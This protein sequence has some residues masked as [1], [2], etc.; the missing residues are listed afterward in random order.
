MANRDK[1]FVRAER[2]SKVRANDSHHVCTD[3]VAFDSYKLAV[4]VASTRLATSTP[5]QAYKC[6]YCHKWHIGNFLR[7]VS[8]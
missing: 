2:V 1:V 8:K 5:R 3:K 6:P 4:R 7:G